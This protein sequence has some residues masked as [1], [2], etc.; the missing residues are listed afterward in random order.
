VQ[1]AALG[2]LAV[3]AAPAL[4]Y[5]AAAGLV[6]AAVGY[7]EVRINQPRDDSASVISDARWRRLTGGISRA[8]YYWG[9]RPLVDALFQNFLN[10]GFRYHLMRGLIIQLV[11][12]DLDKYGGDPEGNCFSYAKT[13]ARL[14]NSVGIDAEPREV[15]SNDEGRFIT[16]VDR[17]IDGRVRGHIYYRDRLVPHYYMFNSHVAVWV[18]SL[19]MYYDP[20]ACSKYANFNSNLIV[21][22]VGDDERHLR[23]RTVPP[24]ARG[25]VDLEITKHDE[26]GGFQR[27]N[28]TDRV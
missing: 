15:R 1:P 28:A 18:P 8:R 23:T 11:G 17:F 20:M 22:V 6:A 24:F 7:Q 3:A 10:A 14:L 5:V 19:R 21:E 13:F 2:A 9:G 4:P 27:V 25:I 16:R 12:T 26:T